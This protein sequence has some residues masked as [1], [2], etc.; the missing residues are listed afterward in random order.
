MGE[1][2]KKAMT[3]PDVSAASASLS[4]AYVLTTIGWRRAAWQLAIRP[5]AALYGPTPLRWLASM[6]PFLTLIVCLQRL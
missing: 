5:L 6:L 3:L 4:L 1:F 2:V